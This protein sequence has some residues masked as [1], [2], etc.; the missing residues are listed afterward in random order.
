[1]SIPT[2]NLHQPVAILNIKF[3]TAWEYFNF[4]QK[5]KIAL[6]YFFFFW[7]LDKGY[8]E[9]QKK[10][11]MQKEKNRNSKVSQHEDPNM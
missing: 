11:I 10:K 7:H 5:T 1:M 8:I 4:Q 6:S 3:G 2:W 9:G